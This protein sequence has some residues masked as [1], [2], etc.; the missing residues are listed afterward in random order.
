MCWYRQRARTSRAITGVLAPHSKLRAAVTPAHRGLG[1]PGQAGA[2]QVRGACQP[3]QVE[4]TVD[5]RNV[6]GLNFLSAVVLVS[7]IPPREIGRRYRGQLIVVVAN[8]GLRGI[9]G[10]SAAVAAIATNISAN[11]MGRSRVFMAPNHI[12]C[13]M[14]RHPSL[15][16]G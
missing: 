13:M 9:H 2:R 8:P 6:G 12:R 10:V 14:R 3:I 4:F 5:C 7:P 15:A 11:T 1:G 16:G